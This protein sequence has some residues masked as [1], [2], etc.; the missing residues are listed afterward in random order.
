MRAATIWLFLLLTSLLAPTGRLCAQAAGSVD[1]PNRLN[2]EASYLVNLF[3]FVQWA[4]RSESDTAT[5]CF[6]E[7]SPLVKLIQNGI[8]RGERWARLRGRELKLNV[9]ADAADILGCQILFLEAKTADKLWRTFTVPPGVL[10][11]S[12]ERTFTARDGMMEFQWLDTDDLKISM[13]RDLVLE[14]GVTISGTL[15]NLATPAAR[16]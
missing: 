14:A 12:D 4:G 13:R 5:L 7:T 6:L 2:L 15:A 16:R 8:A 1:H 3:K 10:T 9:L 11:I